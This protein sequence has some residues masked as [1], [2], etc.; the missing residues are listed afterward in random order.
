MAFE[1]YYGTVWIDS[2]LVY[3]CK[4]C[5]NVLLKPKVETYSKSKYRFNNTEWQDVGI[6]TSDRIDLHSAS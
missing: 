5:G 6:Q 3:G 4:G 2:V 1:K